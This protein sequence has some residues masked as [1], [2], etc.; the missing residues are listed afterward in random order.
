MLRLI[1][2]T[3]LLY[4]PDVFNVLFNFYDGAVQFSNCPFLQ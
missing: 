3:N 1:Y 2:T 4:S